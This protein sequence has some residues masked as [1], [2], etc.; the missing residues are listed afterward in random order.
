MIDS[1]LIELVEVLCF[2]IVL[3]LLKRDEGS[4]KTKGLGLQ[5]R[6]L[7]SLTRNCVCVAFQSL[8]FTKP[9]YMIFF[10]LERTRGGVVTEFKSIYRMV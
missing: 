7:L 4:L 1:F 8:L 3:Q 9:K 2:M 10:P 5:Q 6:G